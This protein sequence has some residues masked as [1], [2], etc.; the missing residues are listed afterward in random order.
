M[1]KVLADD[2][3]TGESRVRIGMTRRGGSEE[4]GKGC[5]ETTWITVRANVF[6]GRKQPRVR[7]DV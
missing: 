1:I 3:V 5:L 6:R 2:T 7:S 4:M